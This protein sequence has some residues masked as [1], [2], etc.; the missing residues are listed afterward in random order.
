MIDSPDELW[1]KRL[2]NIFKRKEKSE[3]EKF[4]IIVSII[5]F[6]D[7]NCSD[8][9]D[10]FSILNLEE[11]IKVINLFENRTIEF[12]SK[13]EVKEAI[14]LALVYYY[15]NIRGVDS[16]KDLKNLHIIDERDFS[17]KSIGRKTNKLNKKINEKI[18]DIFL[19]MENDWKHRI[20]NRRN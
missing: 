5:L 12:P 7:E 20:H 6:N 1:E 2:D 19:G 13:A 10:L 11:F 16:Y 18:L 8:I 17:S 4:L 3:I 14:E 9:S 15:K